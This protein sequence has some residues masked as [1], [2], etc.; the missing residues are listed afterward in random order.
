MTLHFLGNI[1]AHRITCFN[2]KAQALLVEPFCLQIDRYG[3]FE[4]PQVLWIGCRKPPRSLFDLQKH[5]GEQLVECGYQA[6]RR[7]YHPH[8][9]LAR[10]VDCPDEFPQLSQIEWVVDRFALIESVPIDRGVRYQV[11]E[12]YLLN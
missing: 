1:E 8:I 3:Y 5:L 12:T 11:L 6:E 7:A 4:R 10:K 2:Q 9:T